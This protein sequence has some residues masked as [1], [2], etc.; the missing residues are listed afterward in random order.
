MLSPP[1]GELL[2][3][4]PPAK[5]THMPFRSQL[6]SWC[7]NS[8]PRSFAEFT[9]GSERSARPDP[10][11]LRISANEE[12]VSSPKRPARKSACAPSC[13]S[14]HMDGCAMQSELRHLSVW[15]RQSIGTAMP[16]AL[17]RP[18]MAG[19]SSD[20]HITESCAPHVPESYPRHAPE[21]S[22]KCGKVVERLLAPGVEI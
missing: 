3:G 22:K 21:F 5:A 2:L 19:E 15:T 12:K 17:Q 8:L 4:G 1:R 16:P 7:Q 10:R 9:S 18:L 6:L 13:E 11:L 20:P 14:S